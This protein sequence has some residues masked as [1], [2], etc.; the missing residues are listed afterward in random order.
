MKRKRSKVGRQKKEG[1]DKPKTEKEDKVDG[2]QGVLPIRDL[3]KNLG[4][5]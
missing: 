4:C 3:K 2:H 1:E 5:G